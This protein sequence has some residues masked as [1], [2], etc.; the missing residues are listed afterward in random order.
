MSYL[1]TR[2]ASCHHVC[3][4][5]AEHAVDGTPSCSD[6]GRAASV[7]PS[8]AY[9]EAD[10]SLFEELSQTVREG[11][12]SA[13]EAARLVHELSRAVSHRGYEQF[14]ELL[15]GRVPGF[16]PIQLILGGKP[17]AQLR[18]LRMLATIFEAIATS[19]RSKSLP[20]VVSAALS[21][22]GRSS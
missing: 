17:H 11:G 22:A 6:C 7:V 14:F 10:V 20:P 15:S 2:C 19:A 4:A 16:T 13:L 5:P 1:V 9:A 12:I 18:A 3:L 21:S 8:C